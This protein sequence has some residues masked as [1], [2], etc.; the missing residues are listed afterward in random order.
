MGNCTQEE[1]GYTGAMRTLLLCNNWVG[2]QACQFLR[3]QEADIVGVVMHPPGEQS[4]GNEILAALDL[5]QESIFA[6]DCLC[7]PA[8]LEAIRKLK[9][10][11]ALSVLFNRVLRQ[12][13]LNLFPRGVINLHPGYLP[14]NRGQ[15]PNVWSIIE[16]TPCGATLHY[17][18]EGIDTGDIVD[19]KLVEIDVID[20]GESLYRKLEGACVELLQANWS[21]ICNQTA[22]RQPQPCEGTYHRCRDVDEIDEID[23]EKQYKA[24]DLINLLRAR[25]FAPHKGAYFV[26][27]GRRVFLRLQLEYE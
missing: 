11:L 3:S 1:S 6:G 18:D 26:S 9:P 12:E 23:L 25:T 7:E 2:W 16:S 14:F 10:D 24:K 13:F 19:R 22:S 20:T 17:I 4:F 21:T 27:N 15:Y 8:T 5:P